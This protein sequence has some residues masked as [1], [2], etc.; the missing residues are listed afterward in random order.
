MEYG[1]IGAKLGH[2]FSKIIHEKLCDYTYDLHQLPTEEDARDFMLRKDFKAINVTIPYKEFVMPFCDEINEAARAIGAVNTIVNQNGRLIAHNTDFFGFSRLV[3]AHN[4]TFAGKTVLILGTGGTQKTVEAVAQHGGAKK[5]LRVSRRKTEHTLTYNEAAQCDDVQII[6][7]TSPVGMYPNNGECLVDLSGFPL[8][9]A[10]FDAVYNPFETR[11][12]WQARNR[13]VVAAN[14][15]LMLVAQAKYAA[16]YFTGHEIDDAEID[17]VT[18]EIR[19]E[20]TN[21]VLIGMPGCGKTVLGQM[22]AELLDKKFVDLDVEIEKRAGKKIAAIFAQDGEASFRALECA[23]CAEYAKETGLAISTGGGIVKNSENIRNLQQNG[24]L[25]YLDRPLAQLATNGRP[26]ST[27]MDAVKK[28]YAERK[29][30]YEAAADQTVHNGG[31][32]TPAAQKIKEAFYEAVN[33]ERTK[34]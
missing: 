20:R 6:V 17:R 9:E 4:V 31:E 1:L 7:N 19:A 30:L 28:L 11:L 12:L 34:Y 26:L 32:R 27:D 13:G 33:T 25:I 3:A 2:S 22:A 21:L 14:G 16:E 15:L 24:V 8:L 23:V 18:A 10:V 5:I 29:P